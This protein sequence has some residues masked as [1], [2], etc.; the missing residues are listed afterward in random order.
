[1]PRVTRSWVESLV[2]SWPSNT[3]R[4]DVALVTPRMMR[5]MVVFPQP[6]SPTS[7]RV[8]CSVSAKLTPSTAG[9]ERV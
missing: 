1:M 6:D 4:P 9:T 8:S 2:M 3:T 5:P 7:P